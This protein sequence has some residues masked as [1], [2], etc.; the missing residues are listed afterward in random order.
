MSL[1]LTTNVNFNGIVQICMVNQVLKV[2]QR[3]VRYSDGE[4]PNGE[5]MNRLWWKWECYRSCGVVAEFVTA[6]TIT[7]VMVGLSKCEK[8][9]VGEGSERI[10]GARKV[11]CCWCS[12]TGRRSFDLDIYV[13]HL[14]AMYR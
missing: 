4:T 8:R 3:H 11:G 14:S 6:R 5:E 10:Q 1:T 7:V 13:S 2:N 12:T 9:V